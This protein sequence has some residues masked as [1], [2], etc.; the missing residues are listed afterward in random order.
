MIPERCSSK[1]LNLK[2][3]YTLNKPNPVHNATSGTQM[4]YTYE[5][6]EVEENEPAVKNAKFSL[7]LLLQ[8]K[9]STFQCITR[10]NMNG[11]D[12]HNV[13]IKL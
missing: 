5:G 12:L 7:F 11:V 13:S 1:E 8:Q 2:E 9:S 6:K 3:Y 4:F 10:W